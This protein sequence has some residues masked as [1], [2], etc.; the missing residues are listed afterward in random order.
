M[1]RTTIRWLLNIPRDGDSTSVG[2]LC[3]CSIR[4]EYEEW[5]YASHYLHS[6][7]REEQ[8]EAGKPVLLLSAEVESCLAEV[9]GENFCSSVKHRNPGLR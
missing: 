8:S 5:E 3:P 4:E 7:P 6:S 9:T 1:S 2:N